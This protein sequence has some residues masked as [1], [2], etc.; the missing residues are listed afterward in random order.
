MKRSRLR[1]VGKSSAA[2]SKRRIQ[3]L[4]RV[5]VIRRDG[6][7]VLRDLGHCST[8]L[9]AEHLNSRRHSRTF[10][11]LRNIVCLCQFH[12]IFWKK[13]NE[14]RYWELI[15]GKIGPERWA[16]LKEMEKDHK[17]FKANWV[18]IEKALVDNLP[19]PVS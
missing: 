19:T 15:E 16:W 2:A 1:R 18:E 14:R 12:H 13:Q 3:A 10:G 8:V 11:D 9:Q 4:L 6:G 5:N 17:P 7:C